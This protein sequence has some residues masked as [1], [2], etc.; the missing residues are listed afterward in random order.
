MVISSH[1]KQK[2]LTTF[3]QLEN[4][5]IN[6]NLINEILDFIKKEFEFNLNEKLKSKPSKEIQKYL[7]NFLNRPIRVCGMV[8]REDHP[9]GSPFWIKGE[10]GEITKQ[11]VETAQVDLSDPNQMKI[12]E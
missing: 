12:Y 10:D 2:F 6:K 8:K 9:G 11:I 3:S 1:F 5:K 4:E 7:F